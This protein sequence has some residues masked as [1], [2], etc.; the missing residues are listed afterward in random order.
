MNYA[1]LSKSRT[2]AGV[3]IQRPPD[4]AV[5]R[6]HVERHHDHAQYHALEVPGVRRLRDIGAE[7]VRREFGIAP[8]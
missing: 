7:P 2:A 5:H 8:R 6:E 4:Q 3:G 1:L